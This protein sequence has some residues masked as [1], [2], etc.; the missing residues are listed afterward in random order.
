MSGSVHTPE[1]AAIDSRGTAA[2]DL[3]RVLV[4]APRWLL[5][6]A[7]VFAPW[8]YGATRPWAR[9]WLAGLLIAACGMWIVECLCRRRRPNVPWLAALAVII[10]LLQGWFMAWNAHS[11]F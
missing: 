9:E 1:F 5:L 2:I 10:L 6:G 3:R 4:D 7:L 11:S 8:A